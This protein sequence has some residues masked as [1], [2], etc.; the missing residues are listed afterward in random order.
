MSLPPPDE[1]MQAPHS[2][3]ADGQPFTTTN[4]IS[5]L[6]ILQ[7]CLLSQPTGSLLYVKPKTR[8]GRVVFFFWRLNPLAAFT[9]ATATSLILAYI[10]FRKLQKF[11]NSPLLWHHMIGAILLLRSQSDTIEAHRKKNSSDKDK[12]AHEFTDNESISQVDMQALRS[13]MGPRG[14]GSVSFYTD[15]ISLAAVSIT[16]VKLCVISVP[17]HIKTVLWLNCITFL[18]Y[19]QL[20]I[21]SRRINPDD[22]DPV[23]LSQ[24]VKLLSPQLMKPFKLLSL[25]L[26]IFVPISYVSWRAMYPHP[27]RTQSVARGLYLILVYL[28]IRDPWGFEAE[29]WV[30]VKQ[31]CRGG[32]QRHQGQPSTVDVENL[33]DTKTRTTHTPKRRWGPKRNLAG[34]ASTVLMLIWYKFHLPA[35]EN[36]FYGILVSLPPV[37][38]PQ[39]FMVLYWTM[40]LSV[41]SMLAPM[42]TN[43]KNLLLI[44]DL[45]FNVMLTQF[46]LVCMLAAYDS[47]GTYKPSW[48]GWL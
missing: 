6:V 24:M 12:D 23:H 28:M 16:I 8:L 43:R 48:L 11:R 10:W 33:A 5:T 22:L 41:Y 26:F 20:F 30:Y 15:I 47:T 3:A 35:E 2:A 29:T 25:F 45:F 37:E 44:I 9:E 34:Y 17:W 19:H 40:V 42:Q 38:S 13:Q 4:I 14:R 32:R 27:L 7:L 31:L 46:V 39:N 21:W 1:A 18:L 36:P